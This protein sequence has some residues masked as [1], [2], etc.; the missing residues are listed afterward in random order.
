MRPFRYV[1]VFVALVAFLFA[2]APS[3][4]AESIA[5]AADVAQSAAAAAGTTFS[6][7]ASC[8]DGTLKTYCS[9]V[10][11]LTVQTEDAPQ[12]T[13]KTTF[14]VSG[15]TCSCNYELNQDTPADTFV[16]RTCAVCDPVM[17]I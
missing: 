7:T 10:P 17:K 2:V 16:M 5:C 15:T 1:I 6:G 4:R 9:C 11:A 8:P 3:A 13:V 12:W 14:E